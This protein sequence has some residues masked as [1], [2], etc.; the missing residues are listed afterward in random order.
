[1]TRRACSQD[2]GAAPL[3]HPL[4]PGVRSAELWNEDWPRTLHDKQITGFSPLV[5]GMK[6][7][8]RI[9]AT[10]DVGGEANWLSV[11]SGGAGRFLL[12]NDGRLRM[13]EM[14]GRWG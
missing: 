6:S 2:P 3:T 11:V 9:W 8:P 13:V 1:M 4:M 14:M 7:A 5:C 12:V 10:L